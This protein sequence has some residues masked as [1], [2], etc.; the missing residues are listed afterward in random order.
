M[1]DRTGKIPLAFALAVSASAAQASALPTPDQAQSL[2]PGSLRGLLSDV[3]AGVVQDDGQL[4]RTSSRLAQWFN[5]GWFSC[6]YGA[7][8]RC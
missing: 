7:W 2:A 8:R 5:G 4:P 6:F 3:T 1:S